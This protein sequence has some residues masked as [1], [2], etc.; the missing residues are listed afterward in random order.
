MYLGSEYIGIS[1][2]AVLLAGTQWG[3]CRDKL[4]AL[5]TVRTF[6]HTVPES[7]SSR[8][9]HRAVPYYVTS[10]SNSLSG[11]TEPSIRY[12]TLNSFLLNEQHAI[13]FYIHESV[14]RVSNLINV[15]QDATYSVYYISV[16]SS[17]CFGCWHPSSGARTTTIT[18]SGID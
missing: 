14:H 11:V 7:T 16:G 15:Q 9:F 13:K 2:I 6:C 18:A 12:S 1:A 8:T 4:Q 3:L 10:P 17:T 5:D